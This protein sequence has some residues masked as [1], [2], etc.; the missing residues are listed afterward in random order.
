M[1]SLLEASRV[2]AVMSRIWGC[3]AEYSGSAATWQV[4]SVLESQGRSLLITASGTVAGTS[5]MREAYLYH[6]GV[7]K[8]IAL[9]VSETKHIC[10]LMVFKAP[11]VSCKSLYF[12]SK[13]ELQSHAVIWGQILPSFSHKQ[14]YLS[15]GKVPFGVAW[16]NSACI[17]SE[18]RA[19][20][21]D[22]SLRWK[23]DNCRR[24]VILR[25]GGNKQ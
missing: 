2:P 20:H 6:R 4:D 10:Q 19:V 1:S 23:N 14:S 24:S 11:V 13:M 7:H 8:V 21:R 18:A 22:M 3:V 15:R 9:S 16:W 25:A 17:N 5:Y 12:L